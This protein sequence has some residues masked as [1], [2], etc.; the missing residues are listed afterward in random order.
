MQTSSDNSDSND[1]SVHDI[2]ENT[3][4]TSVTVKLSVANSRFYRCFNNYN[5]K[6][7]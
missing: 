2:V 6:I 7:N 5:V 4:N 1:I 3:Q